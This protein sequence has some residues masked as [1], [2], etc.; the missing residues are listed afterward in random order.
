[1]SRGQAT[2]FALAG[3]LLLF[4]AVLLLIPRQPPTENSAE[5]SFQQSAVKQAVN[6]CLA[7]LT[8][9]GL[10]LYGN[11]EAKVA[12]HIISGMAACSQAPRSSQAAAVRIS[13]RAAVADLQYQLRGGTS[14][15]FTYQA[16]L[17]ASEKTAPEGFDLT[18]PLDAGSIKMAPGTLMTKSGEPVAAMEFSLKDKHAGGRENAVVAGNW[19]LS[20]EPEGAEFTKP[21]QITM[22]Y[23]WRQLPSWVLED[24]LRI[25]Y[26]D[27]N[28]DLWKS[29]HSEVN[30]EQQTV[31]ASA[32][33]FTEFAIVYSCS[34]NDL[35]S[36]ELGYL[37]KSPCS[38]QGKECPDWNVKGGYTSPYS[39]P[40]YGSEGEQ[41]TVSDSP[42]LEPCQFTDWDSEDGLGPSYGYEHVFGAGSKPL[43]A[44]IDFRLLPNGN[45]C[46]AEQEPVELRIICDDECTD[47]QLNGRE[48]ARVLYDEFRYVNE[49]GTPV[50]RQ[51]AAL[52]FSP[53]GLR[54]GSNTLRFTVQNKF[55]ACSSAWASLSVKG[56]V[57]PRTC[58]SARPGEILIGCTTT[59][60]P[61]NGPAGEVNAVK[62]FAAEYSIPQRL[63]LQLAKHES[64]DFSHYQEQY[65]PYKNCD[66]RVKCGDQGC[67][68][69]L[70]QINTC[71]GANPQCV[72]T[73]SYE[74]GSYDLCQGAKECNAK[75][76]KDL[77]CNVEA[78]L[79]H[80]KNCYAAAADPV[81]ACTCGRYHGWDYALRCYNGCA[82]DNNY[83]ELVKNA[84]LQ[85]I[86]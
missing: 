72:G 66:G 7:R 81:P 33:H 85:G 31:T 52:T 26:Y 11:D 71:P 37:Y 51:V 61:V 41:I 15:S 82:C 79:R 80:L 43:A 68:L 60:M 24:D 53:A 20:A 30:L 56:G 19:I 69:G 34:G 70:L 73:V 21:I 64:I 2:V 58:G 5:L 28:A 42:S 35:H 8:D 46:V 36:A 22:A 29:V 49:G 44:R 75:D 14:L 9:E 40:I 12:G 13:Q 74:P 45:S 67:S 4:G 83:V 54:S 78:G 57:N 3:M 47:F 50:Q 16:D 1:M 84:E 6:I 59:G 77:Q 55:Q 32:P 27:A 38:S 63:A 10:R 17:T 25:A 62:K 18:L 23:D 39:G 48:Q 65:Q 76:V 86:G